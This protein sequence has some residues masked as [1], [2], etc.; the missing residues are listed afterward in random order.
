MAKRALIFLVHLQKKSCLYLL[1]IL[2]RSADFSPTYTPNRFRP[3]NDARTP[4]APFRILVICDDAGHYAG[5]I[6]Y[7]QFDTFAY[8]EHFAVNP[9]ARGGGIGACAL[10]EFR[11][12]S[13]LPVVLEVERP[14]SNDMADRRIAFYRRNGFHTIDSYDY[15]D[16]RNRDFVKRMGVDRVIYPE[17]LAAGEIITALRHSWARNWFELYNGEIILVGVRLGAQARL[18]G[19][20][21]KDLAT[22]SHRFHI[23]AIRRNHETI[24]PGGFDIMQEND[25]L[26]ITTQ[27]EYID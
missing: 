1:I 24:I 12:M 17:F 22:Q 26:Y 15:M 2:L 19:M 4:G 14:G 13:G 18:C 25:I 8:I 9:A 20:Q 27:R 6:S 11:A 10:R 3:R 23:S 21:L 5:F 7:W 16:P